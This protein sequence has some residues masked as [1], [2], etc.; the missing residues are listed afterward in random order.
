MIGIA[1]RGFSFAV[2]SSMKLIESL[3]LYI[4]SL[5]PIVMSIS[6]AGGNI[7][8]ATMFQPSILISTQLISII[9]SEILIPF[10]M[11]A[12]CIAIVNNLSNK[13]HLNKMVELIKKSI[14]WG[15]GILLTI[16]ASIMMVQGLIAPA[17][18][19]A[20]GKSIKFAIS[21]FIPIV[22]GIL[23]DS[24]NVVVGHSLMLKNIIGT[25]GMIITA[26]ICFEPLVKII[27]LI[28]I[29]YLTA[30]VIQPISD[31]RLPNSITE[32]ASAMSTLA[33]IIVSIEL[34][35]LVNLTIAVLAG[36]SAAA[37]GR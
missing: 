35:F 26:L 9:A 16:F 15:L 2:E 20:A 31:K 8:G 11:V 32:I 17:M 37:L 1:V 25:A 21:N 12:V 30:A 14:K 18:D 7:S 36:G 19:G 29:F 22:G 24:I 3:T 23:S 10:L 5:V 13:M 33:L 4:K 6:L 28:T 34:M 27:A